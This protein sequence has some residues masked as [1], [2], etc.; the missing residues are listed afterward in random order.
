MASK[1]QKTTLTTTIALIIAYSLWG[2]NTPLIKIGVEDIPISIFITIK[3][4]GAAVVIAPFA[5]MSW[6]PLKIKTYLVLITS[7]LI[8]ISIG[9][10]AFYSGLAKAPSINAALLELLGPLLLFGFSVQYL[11][12]GFSIK[13]FLG[14]LIALV[15]TLFVIGQP[16]VYGDA[17]SPVNIG[18]FLFLLAVFCHVIGTVLV[19]PQL[20]K[21]GAAQATFIHLVFG[22]IPIAIYSLFQLDNWSITEVDTNSSVAIMYGIFVVTLANFLLV[23][24][25]KR[26]KAQDIGPFFYIQP[27]VT[28]IVAAIV[29]KEYPN[30][31]FIVGCMLVFLG[32][33]LAEAK[34]PDRLHIHYRHNR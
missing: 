32:I 17:N 16:L 31:V 24:A 8:W 25:L 23:F 11:K 30:S 14:I 28:F 3:M 21:V 2:I 20:N 6:K 22:V 27:I 9:N 34:L 15:G 33:Y 13:T 4:L 18:N 26:K 5:F 29:L 1:K 10:L 12:E 7:A 19:K